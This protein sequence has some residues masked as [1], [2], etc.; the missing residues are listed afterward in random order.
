MSNDKLTNPYDSFRRVSEM[1]EKGLNGLLF[2]SIDKH[3]LIQMT[4]V[5]LE[6][7][8]RYIEMLKRNRELMASYWNIPTKKDVANA[9]KQTIQAD[10]KSVV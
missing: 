2:Q 5:G 7:N 4:K 9:V 10:R 6:A 1:W 3:G 8:A